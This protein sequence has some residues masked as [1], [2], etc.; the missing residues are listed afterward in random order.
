MDFES[1]II[2]LL[3]YIGI[4]FLLKSVIIKND[5]SFKVKTIFSY[6]FLG[7]VLLVSIISLIAD[8]DKNI[9]NEIISTGLF[10]IFINLLLFKDYHKNSSNIENIKMFRFTY[11]KSVKILTILMPILFS[12][13]L[14]YILWIND[15]KLVNFMSLLTIILLVLSLFWVLLYFRNMTINKFKRESIIIYNGKSYM[16]YDLSKKKYFKLSKLVDKTY[17]IILKKSF[18]IYLTEN[19]TKEFVWLVHLEKFNID[20]SDN[21]STILLELL[22]NLECKIV[23]INIDNYSRKIISE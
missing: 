4:Y 12:L 23:D 15:F 11:L 16:K 14:I 9:L 8:K 13:F 19:S 10:F 6:V 3:I 2:T 7:F 1:I 20:N 5:T 18:I 22:E 17:K 21:N